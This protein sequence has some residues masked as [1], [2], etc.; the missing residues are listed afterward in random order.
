MRHFFLSLVYMMLINKLLQAQIQPSTIFEIESSID[1]RSDHCRIQFSRIT[2][3]NVGP[4]IMSSRVSDIAVHPH[5]SKVFYT[6]FGSAGIFKTMNSG[7]T[8]FNL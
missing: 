2:L 4:V 1:A 3:F 6:A 5:D 8:M 7:N